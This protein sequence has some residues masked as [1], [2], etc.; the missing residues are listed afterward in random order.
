MPRSPQGSKVG[1]EPT[2]GA[3]DD[4]NRSESGPQ[5]HES[6]ES[7]DED[8]DDILEIS[9]NG[10]W[11]KNNQRVSAYLIM[12]HRRGIERET[13]CIYLWLEREGGEF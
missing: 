13:V 3:K 12:Y 11:Q 2:G 9:E 10:R 1:T 7:E 6:M 5:N 4:I 8:E